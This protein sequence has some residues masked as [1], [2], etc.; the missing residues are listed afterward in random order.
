MYQK[1]EN[2]GEIV[3]TEWTI[4]SY[5]AFGVG[6]ESPQVDILHSEEHKAEGVKL[7]THIGKKDDCFYVDFN[8]SIQAGMQKRKA[9]WMKAVLPVKALETYST[10]C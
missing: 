2:E 6:A 4:K 5:L 7:L 1:G 3:T 10:A 8:T 9:L